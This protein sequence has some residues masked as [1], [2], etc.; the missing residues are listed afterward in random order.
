MVF[1]PLER[2]GL[3]EHTVNNEVS[4]LVR[5]T[6]QENPLIG[7]ETSVRL[8]WVEYRENVRAF[9]RDKGNCSFNKVSV[10]S[11]CLKSGARLYLLLNYCL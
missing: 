3:L 6:F 11:R 2:K 10:L 4:T 1:F 8:K 5:L 7:Q 9:L